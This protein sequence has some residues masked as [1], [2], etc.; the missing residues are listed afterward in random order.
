[1]ARTV[2]SLQEGLPSPDAGLSTL[3]CRPHARPQEGPWDSH[4][5]ADNAASREILSRL[6]L[7]FAGGRSVRHVPIGQAERPKAPFSHGCDD[8]LQLFPHFSRQLHD[9]PLRIH[10]PCTICQYILSC[11]LHSMSRHV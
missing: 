1:M 8:A 7:E 5:D 2:V 6:L 11:S 9:L 3:R 4:L 10:V